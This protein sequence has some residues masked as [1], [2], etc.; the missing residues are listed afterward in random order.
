MKIAV[1][2]SFLDQLGGAEKVALTLAKELKADLI[3][4]NFNQKDISNFG[5][6]SINIKSLG[7]VSKKWPKRQQ[8]ALNLFKKNKFNN[9]DLLIITSEWSIS[10]VNKKQPVIWYVN[11]VPEI[12][13]NYSEKLLKEINKYTNKINF[14]IANSNKTQR[15]ITRYF[16]KDSILIYSCNRN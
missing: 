13:N 4:T 7:N 15:Q 12:S 6:E 16:K 9:Y 8:Q 14:I 2:H 5:F 10:S 3:T 11:S 1:L